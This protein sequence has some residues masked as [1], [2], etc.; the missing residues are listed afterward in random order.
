VTS[1]LPSLRRFR[2]AQTRNV[3]TGSTT[4]AIRLLDRG[5]IQSKTDCHTCWPARSVLA[6]VITKLSCAMA[7]PVIQIFTIATGFAAGPTPVGDIWRPRREKSAFL[8][9][10]GRKRYEASSTC[11]R[12]ALRIEEHVA[13]RE[14]DVVALQIQPSAAHTMCSLVF[15]PGWEVDS[16]RHRGLCQRWSATSSTVTHLLLARARPDH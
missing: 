16:R 9:I 1:L 8:T 12:K 7:T 10:R 4:E 2:S 3:T 14:D 13:P 15:F 6:A 5:N 11:N